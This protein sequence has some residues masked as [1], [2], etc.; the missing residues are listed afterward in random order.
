MSHDIL[1]ERGTPIGQAQKWD[2]IGQGINKA[3]IVTM[4]EHGSWLETDFILSIDTTC[5]KGIG[6]SEAWLEVH[7]TF[8]H[9]AAMMVTLPP[10]ALHSQNEISKDGEILFVADRSGSMADKMENLKSALHFF[11][12]GIPVGRAFNIWSF[13]SDYQPLWTKSQVYGLESLQQAL[14]FVDG[15]FNSDM[16]GTELLPALKAIIA[17]RDPSLSC[18]VVI[19]TDGQVWRLDETLSLVHKAHQ[20]SK[21]AI[22]FFSLGLGNHVSHSLVEGIA[23]QGGGCSEIITRADKEGW[24]ERVVA[25]LE[26]A[27]TRH[28]HN[29]SLDLGGLKGTTSPEDLG[30]LNPFDAQRIFLLF[31]EGKIPENDRVTLALVSEGKCIPVDVSITRFGTPGA[32]IH[33][34]SARAIL[35]DLERA[36]YNG[37]YQPGES[38]TRECED[39]SRLA[40]GLACKYSLPS[41]WTSLFL[42]AENSESSGRHTDSGT[43]N[44]IVTSQSEDRF[45][46]SRWSSQ[47]SESHLCRPIIISER[48]HYRRISRRRGPNSHSRVLS[49]QR[50][51]S[52]LSKDGGK[53]SS[54]SSYTK[55]PAGKELISL[56]LSH[57][58]FDGSIASGV[59]NE[60]P[61]GTNSIVHILKAWLHGKIHQTEVVIDLVANTALTVAFLEQEYQDSK[62]LWV[63]IQKKGIAYIRLQARQPNLGDEIMAYSRESLKQINK[64]TWFE[65]KTNVLILLC[66]SIKGSAIWTRK[67]SKNDEDQ[68]DPE[69]V[70]VHRAPID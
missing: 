57:Q 37:S 46:R 25:I 29:L 69:R 7:P 22:R 6:G 11:L 70:S 23:K 14:N 28:V 26:A 21:G 44:E 38:D 54:N 55:A 68:P 45:L 13:G 32:L 67:M 60:L 59:L 31:E 34:L 48:Q 50:I 15:K 63:M 10:W 64:L 62:A 24:E 36:I 33:T 8:E 19:L 51:I 39:L 53:S 65:R 5:S 18:D 2:H 20:S 17:A 52:L 58:A 35:D 1:V 43:I 9:Q 12:K 42:F 40:E 61:K 4:K 49:V 16:G 56:I 30:Y 41:K 3:A 27:L 66:R 47:N